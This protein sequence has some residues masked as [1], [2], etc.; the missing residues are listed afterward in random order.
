MKHDI[1]HDGRNYAFSA[2]HNY[3][4]QSCEAE[5]AGHLHRY[6][7]GRY[8]QYD[9]YRENPSLDVWIAI[10]E[11]LKNCKLLRN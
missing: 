11:I 8:R 2:I 7:Y 10:E 3:A 1:L 6:L 4:A 5:A 9:Y